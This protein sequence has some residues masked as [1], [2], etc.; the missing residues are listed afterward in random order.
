M[1]WNFGYLHVQSCGGN[2][3]AGDN[4]SAGR[5]FFNFHIIDL[6]ESWHYAVNCER[7]K[8]SV[9]LQYFF[10]FGSIRL[11]FLSAEGRTSAIYL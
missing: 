2:I 9:A 3:C 7:N 11:K 1:K 10:Q 6:C 4:K 5:F 8:K